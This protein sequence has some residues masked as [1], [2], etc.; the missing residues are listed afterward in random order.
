[1]TKIVCLLL[2]ASVPAFSQF[3]SNARTLRGKPLCTATVTT[4]C[5]P[6]TDSAGVL[7]AP[8]LRSSS[9]APTVDGAICGPAPL[10]APKCAG[11]GG[12]LVDC[13]EYSYRDEA[14]QVCS[15]VTATG[16]TK[17]GLGGSGSFTSPLTTKGDTYGRGASGDVRRPGCP[18]DQHEVADSTTATGWKCAAI[19]SG[20]GTTT[21]KEYLQFPMSSG[22][23][24]SS[25]GLGGWS[26]NHGGPAGTPNNIAT[27]DTSGAGNGYLSSL[28]FMNGLS[29]YAVASFLWPYGIDMA[30]P[31]DLMVTTAESDFSN[32][33]AEL[34]VAITCW[35][36]GQ[37]LAITSW[38]DAGIV[39]ITQTNMSV[40]NTVLTGLTLPGSG[41]GAGKLAGLRI[42]RT[43]GGTF[44]GNLGVLAVALRYTK[45]L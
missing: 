45:T 25:G 18:N 28:G 9:T 13:P 1:M 12:T 6:G 15:V 41:C 8:A 29:K 32:G 33:T 7:V 5:V 39:A 11:V 43:A 23:Y 3:G 30:S 17:C 21:T 22:N 37:N 27:S 31:V 10:A 16:V 2:L 35:D 24:V 34:A 38:T 19:G 42:H 36:V 44:T 26:I 14:C 20:G 4:N 40:V